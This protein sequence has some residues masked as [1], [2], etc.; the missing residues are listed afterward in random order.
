MKGLARIWRSR[1]SSSL[2]LACMVGCDGGPGVSPSVA[3]TVSLSLPSLIGGSSGEG[4]VSLSSAAP[5]GGAVVGLSS[6]SQAAVVPTSMTVAAGATSG[7]FAI[8]TNQV[9]TPAQ[10][11]ITATYDGS[12]ESAILTVQQIPLCGP[13]LSAAVA[14][15]FTIYVDDGD[16]RNHFIPSG[17]FGDIDDVTLNAADNTNPRTGATAIRIDYRSRGPQRFAGIFWQ[18]PANNWGDVPGAGFN[19]TRARQVQFWARASSNGAKA[20]FKVGGV[21]R[22]SPPAPFPDSFDATPTTPDIIEL[23]TDWRQFTIDLTGRDLAR[24]IGGFMVVTSV[25]QNPC[26]LYTSPSPRD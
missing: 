8:T 21:G 1:L 16:V 10:A 7:T 24:V 11:M 26:L 18:C 22:G 23:G 3:V 9:P 15:P 5:Q 13:F 2:A 12:T 20:E 4:V 19:L 6:N 25:P 14:M 17:Y